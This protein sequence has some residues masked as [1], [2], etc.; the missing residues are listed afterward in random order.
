MI[1]ETSAGDLDSLNDAF[2]TIDSTYDVNAI[3]SSVVCSLA[4]DRISGKAYV[5]WGE[6]SGDGQDLRRSDADSPWSSWA[7][8]T[9][10]E[11]GTCTRISCNVY[12]RNGQLRLA[13]VWYDAGIKYDEVDITSET[14]PALTAGRFPDQNYYIGPEKV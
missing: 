4:I 3:N 8:S 11:A 9:E 14:A 13:F 1:P 2:N 6:V 7:S 5:M 12:S 10:E